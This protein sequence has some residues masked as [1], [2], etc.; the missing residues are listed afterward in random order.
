[1]SYA[2]IIG[3]GP[4][5]RYT[6]LLDWGEAQKAALLAQVAA[7]QA[8]LAA[9]IVEQQ[10]HVDAA[11][12]AEAA[13]RANLQ[14]I[15]DAL[16][17]ELLV[18]GEGGSAARKLYDYL[19]AE[20]RKLMA[21]F[22]PVRAALVTLKA[23]LAQAHAMAAQWNNFSASETRQAWCCDLTEDASG[24]VATVDIPGESNLI[25][26]APGGRAW[27]PS[28]GVLAARE[29][30]SPAQAYFNASIL[31]GWQKWKPT[32]RWGT[33]T[34]IDRSANTASV[35]LF[36]ATSSAQ[37]LG[38]NQTSGLQ[39]VPFEYMGCHNRAF[40]D[41][42]RVVVKFEGQDWTKPKIIGFLDNPR[43][44]AF[45]F[46]GLLR[47]GIYANGGSAHQFVFMSLSDDEA[48]TVMSAASLT[49]EAMVDQSG[50]WI[51][52]T[53]NLDTTPIPDTST[54]RW[55]SARYF[56]GDAT[57]ESL[58]DPSSWGGYLMTQIIAGS[59]I[60]Q[61]FHTSSGLDP[62]SVPPEV[63]L[64][65]I[66]EA[67]QTQ[68]RPALPWLV[69]YDDHGRVEFRMFLNGTLYANWMVQAPSWTGNV[70]SD[71]A[72]KSSTGYKPDYWG[73]QYFVVD[74]GYQL[75]SES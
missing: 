1:M 35:S 61:V 47:F 29:L 59:R 64:V 33:I 27:E 40:L 14:V 37:R 8:D 45:P 25:L 17:A 24:Q 21:K 16:V 2:E 41:G 5:G 11:D 67:N 72:V 54:Q 31:P 68:P 53:A 48:S 10:T 7:A 42:D 46:V 74:S 20:H 63:K 15:A 58:G 38:V 36:D 70:D 39:D 60:A 69:P 71:I 18:S 26:I 34:A 57:N 50:T 13:S 9:K 43:G 55:R 62:S 75:Y 30:M 32:Y 51:P 73:Y 49:V 28:D 12:A 4:D 19:L 22:E 66:V 44:C 23:Q 65:V 56:R 6:I 3:G 52:L